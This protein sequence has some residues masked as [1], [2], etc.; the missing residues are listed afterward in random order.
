MGLI[1]YVMSLMNSAR[2]GIGAQSAGVCEAAYREALKYAHEREQFGHPIIEF[3][4]MYEM[5]TNMKAKV[6]ATRA[7]LYETT[8]FVDIYKAYSHISNER[9]LTPEEKDEMKQYQKLADG[10]TPLL[11]LM[12]SEYSNSLAY[13]S[14]Q[15]HGGSGFMKDYPIERIFRDARITTIY[16]GTSQLQ[17]VAAIKGV[18]TGLYAAQMEEYE[19]SAPKAEMQHLMDTLIQMREQYQQAVDAVQGLNDGK[20]LDFHARRLVE[21]AGHIIMGHLLLHQASEVEEYVISAETYIK[22]GK[23]LNT[24][25]WEYI[26]DFKPE[27]INMFEH[28]KGEFNA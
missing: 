22:E 2:L 14:L 10:Y 12:S 19:K 25:R 8:R 17:V 9:K 3:P 15:I 20:L 6:Y 11:K 24:A 5:L 18:T 27:Q 1:K 28:I 21:M 13:D 16:E 23:T 7:L 26:R 4:A